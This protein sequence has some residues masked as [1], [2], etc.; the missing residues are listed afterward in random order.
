MLGAQLED[1]PT[2][3]VQA[4]I[5]AKDSCGSCYGAEKGSRKCCNSCE[6]IISAYMEMGWALKS[7]EEFEQCKREQ[8]EKH[9]SINKEGCRL[10]G[11][12][13]LPAHI[14]LQTQW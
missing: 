6:D 9:I 3:V 11:K 10:T 12:F 7:T 2:E 5:V 4:G 14:N 1:K 8:N 13:H